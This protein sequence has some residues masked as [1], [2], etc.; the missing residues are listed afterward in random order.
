[1]S[2]A[3]QTKITAYWRLNYNV[4]DDKTLLMQSARG[5]IKDAGEYTLGYIRLIAEGTAYKEA[6]KKIPLGEVSFFGPVTI[7]LE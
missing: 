5:E 3:T 2:I 1:M 4:T 6:I 7:E